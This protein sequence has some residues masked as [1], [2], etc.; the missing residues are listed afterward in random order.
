MGTVPAAG[1]ATTPLPRRSR[2]NPI[3]RSILRPI[4]SRKQAVS[5]EPP[6]LKAQ[7]RLGHFSSPPGR[8]GDKVRRAP[9]RLST[10]QRRGKD[11]AEL[12]RPLPHGLMADQDAASRQHLIH[13]PQAE[14]EAK[15]QPH[16]MSDDLRWKPISREEGGAVIGQALTNRTAYGNNHGPQLDDAGP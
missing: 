1:N 4:L 3:E 7:L 13:H 8:R 2:G 11:P 16:N 15:I 9:T 12:H 14:R 10:T 6:H 5:P